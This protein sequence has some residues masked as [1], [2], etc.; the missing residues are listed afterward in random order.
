MKTCNEK[1]GSRHSD[2]INKGWH[3]EKKEKAEEKEK[4]T[5]EKKL[6][7]FSSAFSNGLNR[8]TATSSPRQFAVNTS[9]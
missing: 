6:T 1:G 7:P 5:K 3:T 4:E 9:A 2:V 8:F